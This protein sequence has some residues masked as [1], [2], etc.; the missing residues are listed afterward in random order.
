MFIKTICFKYKDT[1]NVGSTKC[2]LWKEFFLIQFQTC[3]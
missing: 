2:M 3:L 1:Q